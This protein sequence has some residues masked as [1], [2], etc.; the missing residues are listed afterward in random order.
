ML[1][2]PVVTS[3]TPACLLPWNLASNFMLIVSVYMLVV[4][5]LL[6]GPGL[7]SAFSF[8]FAAEEFMF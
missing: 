2:H 8:F 6:P 5:V 1:Q 3:L 4:A 7:F